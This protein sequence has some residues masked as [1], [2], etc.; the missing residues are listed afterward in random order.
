MQGMKFRPP[1]NAASLFRDWAPCRLDCSIG[2]DFTITDFDYA[3][4]K[5]RNAIS[6]DVQAGWPI[7]LA[8]EPVLKRPDR[9]TFSSSA[10]HECLPRSTMRPFA[11][12][13]TRQMDH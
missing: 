6:G 10:I 7:G 11:K 13:C 9:S 4:R 3:H 12:T 1:A 5:P 2:C 8:H